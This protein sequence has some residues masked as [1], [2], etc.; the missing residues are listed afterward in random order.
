[1]S[2]YF[3]CEVLIQFF[4]HFFCI[5]CILPNK[6]GY[7]N[8][9]FTYECKWFSW[10]MWFCFVL[11]VSGILFV[12]VEVLFRFFGRGVFLYLFGFFPMNFLDFEELTRLLNTKLCLLN[13]IILINRYYICC[14]LKTIHKQHINCKKHTHTHTHNKTTTTRSQ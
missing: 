8:F 7:L 1:M 3:F 11:F 5:Y 14:F 12:W 9:T 10:Y 13:E 6:T 4:P 2:S